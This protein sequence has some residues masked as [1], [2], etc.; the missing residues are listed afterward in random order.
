M[1]RCLTLNHQ[2][3]KTRLGLRLLKKALMLKN[4]NK[5]LMI[6]AFWNIRGLNKIGR[7]E[8]LKDFITTNKLDFI[9]IQESKKKL[10]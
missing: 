1:W 3:H 2:K 4:Q 8:C 10:L 5:H 6:G 9:G 7:I